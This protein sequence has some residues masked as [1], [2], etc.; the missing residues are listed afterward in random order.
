MS[1]QFISI[2]LLPNVVRQRVPGSKPDSTKH[3]HCMGSVAR[4]IMR[5]GQMSSRCLQPTSTDSPIGFRVHRDGRRRVKP[6]A[7]RS[8]E[9]T[10][11]PIR[12][13]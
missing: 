1:R 6:S 2:R 3:M 8:L 9:I 12:K 11:L 13:V 4:Y 7:K 5:D 10:H